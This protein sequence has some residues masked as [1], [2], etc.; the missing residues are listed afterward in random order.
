MKRAEEQP[1]V[2]KLK[3]ITAGLTNDLMNFKRSQTEVSK[4]TETL[5]DTIADL[6][7]KLVHFNINLKSNNEFLINNLK[8]DCQRLKSRIVS[9]PEALKQAI[10]EMNQSL[11]EDKQTAAISE[12]KAQQLQNKIDMLR[13][14][15]QDICGCVLLL[16]EAHASK[17]NKQ[18]VT[19]K[20]QAET[21]QRAKKE[22]ELLELNVIEVYLNNYLRNNYL[23]SFHPRKKNLPAL[24]SI[25]KR[26]KSP[27]I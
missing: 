19:M 6:T 16:A 14:V 18:D 10:N 24:K 22:A 7:Q 1:T 5:K 15:E 11:K 8:Q 20:I 12:R 4:E 27:G 13:Q 2:E 23:D 21:D 26:S 25:S 9:N 3:K 17:I